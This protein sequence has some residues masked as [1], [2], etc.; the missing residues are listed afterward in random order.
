[1]SKYD[2]YLQENSKVLK[3]KLNIE[4]ETALDK[5]E[6]IKANT[7]MALLYNSGFFDVIIKTKKQ[8]DH[9]MPRQKASHLPRT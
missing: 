6:S 7:K 9:G 8:R 4:D 5:A 2:I 3:N 1:M